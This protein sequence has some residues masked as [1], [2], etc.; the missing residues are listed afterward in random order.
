MEN[1]KDIGKAFK[2]KLQDFDAPPDEKV[3]ASIQSNLQKEKKRR[4]ILPFWWTTIATVLLLGIG[5]MVFDGNEEVNN[6]NTGLH[7]ENASGKRENTVTDNAAKPDSNSAQGDGSGDKLQNPDG[8]S[9]ANDLNQ[10]E[11]DPSAADRNSSKTKNA[12]AKKKLIENTI[13]GKNQQTVKNKNPKFYA[14]GKKKRQ[15][16]NNEFKSSGVNSDVKNKSG[17]NESENANGQITESLK[18]TVAGGDATIGTGGIPSRTDTTGSEETKAS[19]LKKADSLKVLSK[20]EKKAD[21]LQKQNSVGQKMSLF[22]YGS[23]TYSKYPSQYSPLSKD[24]KANRKS[25]QIVGSYGAYVTY[26]SGERWSARIG[27]SINNSRYITN[28]AIVNTLNYTNINYTKGISNIDIYLQSGNTGTMDIIQDISYM[29]VP[30][31]VKYAISTNKFG[32][33]AYGGLSVM[34]LGNNSVSVK[35][36]NGKRFNIGETRDLSSNAFSINAGIGFDFKLT[37][38]LKVNFEPIFKYHLL[39]YKNSPNIKPYTFG[40]LTGLQFSLK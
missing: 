39:D 12:S 16:G 33:N 10:K 22:V 25:S 5:F 17:I 36:A 34:F 21:T 18:T 11:T 4:F 38:R 1:R 9:E 30:L 32:V 35:T 37:R 28:D 14:F 6:E 3:W 19:E 23:P 31:E 13:V 27:L 2:E 20:N 8:N 26:E 15:K 7:P 40:A 24:L 29:E